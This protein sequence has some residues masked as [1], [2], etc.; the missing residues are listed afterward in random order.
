MERCATSLTGEGKG[1]G[2][3]P[4]SENRVGL[5]LRLSHLGADSS[6]SQPNSF[7][8]AQLGR[9]GGEWRCVDFD[10]WAECVWGGGAQGECDG[11]GDALLSAA[12]RRNCL[13]HVDNSGGQREFNWLWWYA[14]G[15]ISAE[16]GPGELVRQS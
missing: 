1:H 15:R 12:R 3:S 5:G 2:P 10:L 9:A 13:F 6:Q 16:E 8:C 14:L 7:V 4:L 11:T